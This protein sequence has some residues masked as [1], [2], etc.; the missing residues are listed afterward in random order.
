MLKRM[1]IYPVGSVVTHRG[2]PEF[3]YGIIVNSFETE[4]EYINEEIVAM[5]LWH[6]DENIELRETP[7]LHKYSE[8]KVLNTEVA[9]A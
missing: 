7:Q 3:G 1:K 5:I 9:F 2:K 6:G 4:E 8:L